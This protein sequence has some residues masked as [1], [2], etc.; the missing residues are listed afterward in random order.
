[1]ESLSY[2][3][4]PSLTT[5]RLGLRPLTLADTDF[6][7][8]HFADP[9]VAKYLM[10]APPLTDRAEAEAIIRFYLEPE[11]KNRNRWGI[12]LGPAGPLIGTCGFHKW[13]QD[14][15]HAEVGY[16]LSPEHWGQGYMAEALH[17]AL[18]CGFARM[19]LHRVDA[20]VYVENERS[21]RL[22]QKLGFQ[23]EGILRD[24]FC[25]DGFFYDHYVL[26]LLK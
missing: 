10:D 25:Q 4:F 13:D 16:D 6:V 2:L 18:D 17:A 12:A 1:M 24:Y 8:Q 21:V 22:L 3:P 11:A 9:L 19:N 20:M 5:P 23:I 14:H 26:A 15:H 7:F